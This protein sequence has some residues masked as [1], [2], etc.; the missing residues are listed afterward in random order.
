MRI[1]VVGAGIGGLTAAMCLRDAGHDVRV[2]ESVP[3]VRPLGVGINV[4]SSGVRILTALGLLDALDAVAIRTQ[5]FVFANRHGQP[6]WRDPRGLSGGYPW[7]Q[8]SIHRGE[9]QMILFEAAVRRLGAANV[10]TGHRLTTFETAPDGRVTARFA[11]KD[12]APAGEERCD[13]LVGA[14]GI[15]STVRA[16]FFPDEGPPKWN[17]VMMWRGTTEGAPFLTGAS[18]VQAGH[19][20]QKFVCYPISRRLAGEGR[21][22]INWIADLYLGGESRR[23][24]DWNRLGRVEDILPKFAGWNFGW[25]DVPAIIKGAGAIYEFPMVDRDPLPRWTH[26]RVTLLGDAAHPMYPIG[27]NG[28]TQAILD[29]EALAAALAEHADPGDALRA[30][31]ARRLPATARI[32]ETNRA[33]GPDRVLDIVEERAPDGF[34]DLESVLPAAEL[35]SI[36]GEYKR[37]VAMDRDTLRA[38]AGKRAG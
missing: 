25:L 19:Q 10:R 32:V 8:F 4:Q 23:R 13:V 6:I 29:G 26:G 7:P 30:Y 16:A 35:E 27:S 38:L 22:L 2:F 18:M 24:E 9:L 15:H 3:E 21:V 14:D 20:A 1:V 12:G 34:T 17:G 36:V 5:E 11:D 33:R 37:I 28:A 31:E